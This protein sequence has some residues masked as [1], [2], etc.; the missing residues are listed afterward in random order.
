MKKAVVRQAVKVAVVVAGT[1]LVIRVVIPAVLS[2]SP[3]S[4]TRSRGRKRGARCAPFVR[5]Y[6]VPCHTVLCVNT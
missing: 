6:A 2:L 5:L 1:T 4:A 3:C